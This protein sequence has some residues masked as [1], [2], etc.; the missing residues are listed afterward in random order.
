MGN[1]IA[2]NHIIKCHQKLIKLQKHIILGVLCFLLRAN[3]QII[4]THQVSKN[5]D[6]FS[7]TQDSNTDDYFILNINLEYF[8]VKITKSQIL[9]LSPLGVLK[10]S[11][12]FP[13]NYYCTSNLT[14]VDTF[15]YVYG[16]LIKNYGPG[17]DSYFTTVYKISRNLEVVKQKILD[18]IQDEFTRNNKI[19]LKGNFLYTMETRYSSNKIKLY[20]LDKNLN[21]LDSTEFQGMLASDLISYGNNLLISGFGFPFGSVYGNAQVAEIDTLFN[22]LSRFNLDSLSYVNPGCASKVGMFP[23][24]CNL[25]EINNKKYIASGFYPVV[26]SATCQ[27]NYRRVTSCI[28]DNQTVLKTNISGDNSENHLA[29]TSN[30]SS[31]KYGRIYSFSMKGYNL[32]NPFPPQSN[33]TS[34]LVEKIDTSGNF[35]WQKYYGEPDM[36]YCPYG[37]CATSDSGAVICGMRYNLL[38]PA[39]VGACEGFVMKIDKNGNFDFV[40]IND[41]EGYTLNKHRCFPNPVGEELMFD[42]P[43]LKETLNIVIYDDFG[44]QIK[45]VSQYERDRPINISN[46]KPGIYHYRAMSNKNVYTGKFVKEE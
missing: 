43:L 45:E 14:P 25:F 8:P 17:L 33:T 39:V 15:Y 2:I 26:Y 40:G 12:N 32:S 34:I 36:Y 13:S 9:K 5:T 18:S 38:N 29:S 24:I 7:I 30:A 23:P 44:K 1:H 19:V 28:M 10:D 41:K 6:F 3:A 31:L 16:T 27:N 35:L 4:Y 22:V 46:L 11:L 42:F 20:K 21:K 37:I